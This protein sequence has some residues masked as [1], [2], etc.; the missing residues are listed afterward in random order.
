MKIVVA[1]DSFK[2]CL[3]AAE[4]A[5]AIKQG[6]QKIN[7][8]FSVVLVPMADG[9]EGTVDAFMASVGGTLIST[10]VTGPL[11]QPVPSSFGILSDQETAVVEMAAASGLTLVPPDRRNPLQATS[12]GT[13]E[14][15]KEALDRNIR[16]LIIGIGGSATNDGGTGMAAALGVKFLDPAGDELPQGGGYLDQLHQIDVQG[17]D[18]RIKEIDIKVACDVTNPLCGP[19]GASAIYGL[20]KGATPEMIPLLDRNL[21]HY[22]EILARTTGKNVKDLPGAGAAGGMGAA[23]MAFLNAKLQPGVDIIAETACLDHLIHNADLVITG[24]GRTDSQTVNGKVP[25][26]VA[27]LAKRHGVPVVC[28]SG[29]LAGDVSALYDHGITSIFSITEG[30]ISLAEAIRDAEP[31]LEK[32][33]ERIVRVFLAGRGIR[34]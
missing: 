7:R 2:G 10:T 6:I 32:A 27:R 33:A 29:G 13:G 17:L 15:I 19:D 3:T 4:V 31:L 23:L 20:Q 25:T 8:E 9:G 21:A 30:P 34:P 5:K 22:A 14:L 11:G 26:G 1:P 24:E 12:F 18:A 28:L 16:K